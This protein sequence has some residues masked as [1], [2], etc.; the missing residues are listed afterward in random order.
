MFSNYFL[1]APDFG[2]PANAD[3]LEQALHRLETCLKKHH[4]RI[5]AMIIE[6]IIQCAGGF[7]IYDPVF[8]DEAIL[9]C[10]H[11][12]VLVIHDEV[13]TGFGR[14]TKLF[15]SSWCKYSPDIMVL[16]KG[17]TAGYL[18]HAATMVQT[19]VFEAFYSDDTKHSFMHGPTFMGNPL[20]CSVALA[21][22]DLFKEEE[23][24]TAIFA[25]EKQLSSELASLSTI[26]SVRDI[27]VMG[28]VGAVELTSLNA[29]D[30]QDFSRRHGVWLR[31]IGNIIYI[32]PAYTISSSDLTHLIT[33]IKLFL[34]EQDQV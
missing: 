21:S 6:P 31:P 11:Y 34:E 19:Y 8:L 23:T 30:F 17:L 16:G 22:L 9:L 5:A 4:T 18:G 24:M 2:Y 27:R 33:V 25:I 26:Q 32:M 15:A 14:T 13:A 28:A 3:R 12:H 7:N 1:E 10:R 29:V 20:A